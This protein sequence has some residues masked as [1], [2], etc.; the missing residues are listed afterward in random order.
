M[1]K[2]YWCDKYKTWQTGR[3]DGCKIC[4][5]MYLSTPAKSPKRYSHAFTIAFSVIS[6]HEGGDVTVDELRFGL[7]NR[8]LDMEKN[9]GEIIEACGMPYDTY[10][11]QEGEGDG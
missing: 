1:T 8:L 2:M 7:L 3:C 6:E 9:P 10:E 4:K 11:L 5:S